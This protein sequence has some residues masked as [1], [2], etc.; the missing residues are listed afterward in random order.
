[1]YEVV[2]P[3]YFEAELARRHHIDFIRFLWQRTDPFIVGQHT[4]A[5]CEILDEAIEKYK[6][7]ISSFLLI[8]I[9]FRH[10]KSDIS[11]R[12]LPANFIGKFP[13]EDVIVTAYAYPLVRTFSRFARDRIMCDPKYQIVYP[14]VY[15]DPKNKGA[16][17]WGIQDRLGCTSWMGIGGSVTGKGGNLIVVD[18]FCKGRAEAES[19]VVRDTAWDSI[20]ND[21]MTRRAPVCIFVIPATPWNVDDIFGRIETKQKDIPEFPNFTEI[22]FPAFSE[23]YKGGILFPERF[24]IEWYKSQRAILGPYASAGLLQCEPVARGGN[25]FEVDKIKKYKNPPEDIRWCRG[26][27]LASTEKER[28]SDNPD[29]TVGAKVGVRWVMLGDGQQ[30]PE[31]YVDDI[32]EGRW[33]APARNKII[34]STTIGDGPGVQVAIEGYGQGKDAYEEIKKILYGIRTVLKSQLPGDKVTKASVLEA[35]IASGNFY[36]RSASWNDRAIDQIRSFSG[37]SSLHD[38]IVDAIVVAYEAHNPYSKRVWPQFQGRHIRPLDIKWEKTQAY[39]DGT[40]HYAGV[41]QKEDLSVWVVLCLW[42]AYKGYLIVYDAFTCD[43]PTPGVVLEK[44]IEKMRLQK[45]RS[46]AIVCNSLMWEDKGYSKN[47]ALQYKAELSKKKIY[48]KIKKA[49][50]YDEYASIVEVGQLMDMD[51]V[52]VE[53]KVSSLILQL[54]SWTIVDRGKTTGGR[55][56]AIDDGFCRA[57]CLVDSELRR[58]EQWV[59]IMKPQFNDY[60]NADI[61]Q[62]SYNKASEIGSRRTWV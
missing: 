38:D 42:D 54:M 43:S 48:T 40:L 55:P 29:Y 60:N 37:K 39:T 52:F 47:I 34:T 27:D 11:S 59:R 35:P 19:P 41:W 50:N 36:M 62:R 16:D 3:V 46:D 28:I 4:E 1:M 57:L 61:V 14:G 24:S 2:S 6:K 23:K 31:I 58:T 12:Y 10:G 20:A 44:L 51:M 26:W 8:K 25:I 9:P 53:A 21:V 22:K 49:I 18:D 13:D 56:D 5:T 7:G 15:L 17:T 45:V 30:I 32:I 33:A